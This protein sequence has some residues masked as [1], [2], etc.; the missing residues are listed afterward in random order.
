VNV[1]ITPRPDV[2]I[3]HDCIFAWWREIFKTKSF[4]K[5]IILDFLVFSRLPQY[6]RPR[7]PSG[8]KTT[9]H[10]QR[11]RSII[12]VCGMSCWTFFV[13]QSVIP[14]PHNNYVLCSNILWFVCAAATV[15]RSTWPWSYT[16]I[17]LY[18]L[19][20]FLDNGYRVILCGKKAREWCWLPTP[21]SAE[22]KERVLIS[23]LP[24]CAFVAGYRA[25]NV[26]SILLYPGTW[27]QQT[28]PKVSDLFIKLDG[29]M[30][31][32]TVINSNLTRK[33]PYIIPRE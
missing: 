22:V 9:S 4:I 5:S 12:V 10:A 29:V 33:L 1:V 32:N 8:L 23:L 16:A 25:M 20:S 31:Q 2:K 3:L 6:L 27:R 28:A 17:Q 14:S 7:V 15:T 26:L 24:V 13:S 19:Y 21:S 30:T 18:S 11:F